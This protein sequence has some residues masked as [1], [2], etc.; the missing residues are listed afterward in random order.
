VAKISREVDRRS[1]LRSAIAVGGGAALAPTL[2]QGLGA[3]LGYAAETGAPLPKAGAGE[4]GYG[5]LQPTPDK[6]D[7]VVRIALPVGFSYVTFGIEGSTMSDG[8]PTPKAHDGMAAFR[9]PNGHIRLIRNHEL[10]DNPDVSTI[11]GDPATAYDPIAGGGTTS[12]E[13]EVTSDGDRHL[14]RDF[15]SLNG[16]LVNCAGGATPW[17][18]WLTCEET[19]TGTAAGWPK[20]HGYVFEVPVAVEDAVPAVPF[21]S[22]GRFSHEAVAVDPVSWIVYETEDANPCGL[23]RF[24]PNQPGKLSEGGQLQMLAIQNRPGYDT[25]YD[26]QVGRVLLAEWVDIPDPDPA[27]AESNGLSV[28][29]QGFARGGASFSRLEGCWVSGRTLFFNSTSGGN[30][31]L[32][33]VWEYQPMGPRLGRLRLIFESPSIEVLSSPDNL[34]VSPRGGLVLCEDGDAASQ[35][36]RGLTRDGRIFDFAE[37]LLNDREWAGATYSPDGLTLFV[38][39]Q[40][41]TSSDGPGNLGYTFAI[42]GPWEA[43]AL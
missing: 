16:T 43:G 22:M 7:G 2:L 9:L 4:G 24:L 29:Q 27:D 10:R 33:Q 35:F 30:A 3:R 39:I 5:P 31:E 38:N 23:Y 1:F 37:F 34:T 13:I 32:G 40:G 8:N 12:L 14:V 26:Q 20:P 18:S 28:F 17:G 36:L 15:V 21:P 42:W 6:H 11:I 41:D 25:R 19:T